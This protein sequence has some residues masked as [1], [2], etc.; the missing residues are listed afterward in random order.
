MKINGN[1]EIVSVKFPTLFLEALQPHHLEIVK[2]KC[3][4]FSAIKE[5]LKS[6][7]LQHEV[8]EGANNKDLYTIIVEELKK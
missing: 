1:E 5:L 3:C 8:F 4:Y 6:A 2:Q 7:K